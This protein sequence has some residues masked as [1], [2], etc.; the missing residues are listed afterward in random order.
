MHA[1]PS[2][3]RRRALLLGAAIIA[4]IGL[5]ADPPPDADAFPNFDSY[6]QISGYRPWIAGDGAAFQQRTGDA[7]AGVY[8]IENLK[9]SKDL[10]N[11]VNLQ[12]NGRALSGSDDY[13]AQVVVTDDNLGSVDVGY[14]LFRTFYD[15]VGGFFPLNDSFLAM[16]PEDLHVDRGAFW[17]NL[18]LQ[19]ATGPVV[20]LSFRDET[21]TGDKDSTEWGLEVAPDAKIV[22][23]ALSGTAA[24]ANT[25][26]LVPNV[27][28]LAEHHKILEA[29]VTETA[30]KTTEVLRASA[31]WVGNVDTRYYDRYLGSHV[32]A[33][34][35]VNV[36]DDQETT[37]THSFRAV[38]QTTT[39]IS[40]WL[41][42]EVGLSY[43]HLGGEDGGEWITPSYSTTAKAIFPTVTAGDIVA[44]PEVNDYVADAFLHLQPLRDL[45]ADVGFR[46][47]S[48][49]ISDQGSFITEAL[50]STAKTTAASNV[51]TATD[52]TYSHETD[53]VATP[54][55]SLEYVG[56]RNVTFYGDFDDRIDRGQQHWIN[57]YAAIS[58]TGTAAEIL[59]A[60][61]IAD[62]FFQGADESNRDAKL[63][64]NWNVAPE[65]TIRA[66]VFRKDHWNTYLGSDD[67]VGT[68]SYG[69][70]F[71]TGY[72][73]TGTRVSLLFKP[74]PIISFNTS[75]QPQIGRMSVTS[76]AVSGGQGTESPS[77][78]AEAQMFG[79]TV[80]LTPYKQLYVQASLNIVYNYISTAYPDTVVSTT[81]V[82]AP[83]F[84]NANNNYVT[85]SVLCG[86]VLTRSTDA[87]ISGVWQHANN[88]DPAIAWGGIPYGASFLN[89]SLTAGIK[90]KL[91]ARLFGQAKVGYLVNRDPTTGGFTNYHGPLAYISLLYSL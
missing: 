32:T 48:E 75:Y 25:I 40:S 59:S 70:L 52:P 5:Q 35:S 72:T 62:V 88:F 15:G 81:P 66:E 1:L 33:D 74:S 39:D 82:V 3:L 24:P 43:F 83:P 10:S 2:S 30:G 27:Q 37:D 9:Y 84:Q 90:Q 6:I 31:D 12:V 47:E 4:P 64:M 67:I 65:L 73:F 69:A 63:G 42:S 20:T 49:T 41:S 56:L 46:E 54:E 86:F 68:G 50:T 80:D 13:L 71:A 44:T 45:R 89:E 38:S 78:R 53:H 29:T 60:V 8:G 14:K 79:E 51:T 21:R 85:A 23:G 91:S 18:K 55:V 61:P 26:A 34:P 36:L 87:E 76:D 17:I 22:G 58:Q 16:S 19:R 28:A 57:P 11:D 77:G 7:T